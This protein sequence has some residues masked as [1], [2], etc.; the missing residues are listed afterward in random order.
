M[1]RA[2]PGSRDL[3]PRVGTGS[4]GFA[5]CYKWQCR[6]GFAESPR[7]AGI[8]SVEYTRPEF[9]LWCPEFRLDLWL[10]LEQCSGWKPGI[11]PRN[12]SADADERHVGWAGFEPA[13]VRANSG[14]IGTGELGR[15]RRIN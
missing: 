14:W 4:C 8:Q 6:P 10:D 9:R 5:E 13:G 1:W 11:F 2:G 3:S 7:H 15:G 12:G